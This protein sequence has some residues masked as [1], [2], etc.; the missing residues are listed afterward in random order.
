MHFQHVVVVSVVLIC[1]LKLEKVSIT[2]NWPIRKK[3]TE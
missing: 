3:K 2:K 1:N